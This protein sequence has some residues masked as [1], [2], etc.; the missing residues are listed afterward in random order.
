MNIARCKRLQKI[1]EQIE[2]LRDEEQE[3]FDNTPESLQFSE[4]GEKMEEAI[5]CLE[6]A[7]DSI[8]EI[9]EG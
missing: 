6:T 3:A 9:T 4:R 5:Q 2:E 1:V 8:K 7:I